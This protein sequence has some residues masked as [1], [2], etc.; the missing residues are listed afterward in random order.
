ALEFAQLF[1]R[2]GSRV[3]IMHRGKEIFKQGE[4]QVVA[5]LVDILQKEGVTIITNA[6]VGKV[7]SENN[8]K[9]ISYKI[10]GQSKELSVDEILL[11]AGK[12]PNTES[13]H[14][15]KAGVKIS[16]NKAIIVNAHL[17]TSINHIYAV[18]DVIAAPLRL[19][20]VAGKEGTLAAQ[21]LLGKTQKN[22]DYS[23]VPYTIFTDPQLAS[24]GLTEEDQMKKYNV[25]ACR[26]VSFEHVPKA[27]I[28]GRTEGI[29]KMSIH[30]ET[31][32]VEGVHILSP[33]AG[34]LIAEAMIL[35]KNK[36]T[37]DEVIDSL[38]M[39]PTLSEA[40]KLVARSFYGDIS[41]LSCCV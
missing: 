18:G 1:A 36:N 41:K 4:R 11:A 8:K 17:Q 28:M 31:K 15:E 38:P 2:F 25:C 34:E 35:V 37:I 7:R 33:H 29:I 20:T 24:V 39:F 3:T 13:L 21:N 10:D 5:T 6:L 30:T 9:V 19:E 16:E 32:V 40:I 27:I 14:V 22:I 23:S 26:S 12:I